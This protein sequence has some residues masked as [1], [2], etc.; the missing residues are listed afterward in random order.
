MAVPDGTKCQSCS[1]RSLSRMISGTSRMSMHWAN[2]LNIIPPPCL[3]RED[4]RSVPTHST[5]LS[6]GFV[7]FDWRCS[8]SSS[9]SLPRCRS[10]DSVLV[11]HVVAF[12]LCSS[13]ALHLS[14]Q[15][16]FKLCSTL[17]QNEGKRF[18]TYLWIMTW[19]NCSKNDFALFS[20]FIY[21]IVPDI[22]TFIL[23]N[24]YS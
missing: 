12:P 3:W 2:N 8:K 9:T 6:G 17:L 14:E 1:K 21:L 7:V 24:C 5:S 22:F 19:H 11:Y 20:C 23:W 15:L 16:Q 4:Y 10:S 18:E 13:P